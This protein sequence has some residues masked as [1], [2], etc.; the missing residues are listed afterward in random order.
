MPESSNPAMVMLTIS[1]SIRF[2]KSQ[3]GGILLDVEQ[4]AIFSLNRVGAR[5]IDLLQEGHEPLLLAETIGREFKV[6]PDVVRSDIAEFLASLREQRLLKD[7]G[8]GD[9]SEHGGAQ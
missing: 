1:P 5:V 2:T 7:A 9:R 4:G 8:R 3:D 6:S